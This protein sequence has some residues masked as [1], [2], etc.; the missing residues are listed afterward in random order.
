MHPAIIKYSNLLL[1]TSLTIKIG[2]NTLNTI[3]YRVTACEQ[4][5]NVKNGKLGA[6]PT[7]SLNLNQIK[8]PHQ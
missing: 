3:I 1:L 7:S 6:S 8:I 4:E 2:Y 5:G